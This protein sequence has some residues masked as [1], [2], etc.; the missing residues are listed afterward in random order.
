MK[1]GLIYLRFVSE[2]EDLSWITYCHI[3]DALPLDLKCGIIKIIYSLDDT[4]V[5]V[6]KL[7]KDVQNGCVIH[8]KY[9]EDIA[10][11]IYK[12]YTEMISLLTNKL[13]IR[14]VYGIGEISNTNVNSIHT[15]LND[16]IT[17]KVGR[18]LDKYNEKGI[19]KID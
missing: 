1:Y 2:T 19:F 5:F 14:L 7:S 3:F 4:D 16:D 18:F 17:V 13:S 10:N 8:A 11:I 15:L 6:I 9:T 12:K